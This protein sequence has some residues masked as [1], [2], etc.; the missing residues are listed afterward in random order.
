M[1]AELDVE[2]EGAPTV[3]GAPRAVV[4]AREDEA[5]VD[6]EAADADEAEAAEPEPE[7]PIETSAIA[8]PIALVVDARA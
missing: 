4:D 2:G 7:H 6:D 3:D 5:D 1:S 8:M